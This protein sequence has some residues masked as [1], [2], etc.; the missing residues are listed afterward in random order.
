M[1]DGHQYTIIWYINDNRIL[2][3]S[4]TVVNNIIRAIEAKFGTTT[5][6]YGKAHD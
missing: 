3:I 4:P 1:I 5:K 6:T 2:H